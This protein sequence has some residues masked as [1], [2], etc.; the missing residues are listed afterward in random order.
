MKLIFTGD[1]NFR[2]HENLTEAGCTDILSGVL[3]YVG[4]A[5]FRIVNLE[6]PLADAHLHTPIYKSGPNLI[7]APEN[8]VFLNTFGADAVTLANNHTGDYG[9]SAVLQTMEVLRTNGIR[10]CGAGVNIADAYNACRLEKDGVT[11]SLI[12]V[13]ENE[14]G[15]ATETAAGSAGYQPRLL[16]RKIREEKQVSDAVIVVFHGGNE[17]NPLPSPDTQE[18][19]RLICDMGAD[20][21]IAGH[22]HCPQGYEMF[23]GKPIVYS[24]G[25]F[26]F[27]SSTERSSDD[28]WHYGYMTALDIGERCIDLHL[29]PYR[30]SIGADK[31][32]VFAGEDREKMLAYIDRLSGTIANPTELENYF[33][34]WSY[35][36]KWIPQAPR[37]YSDMHDYFSAGHYNLI[38]CESHY[39]QAKKVLELCFLDR[40]ED[41]AV[42]A[43]KVQEQAKM[44]V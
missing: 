10:F 31:I 5:D 44:P 13:C 39:S 16:L 32:H 11:V 15:M 29:I 3:P 24:M 12:S 37:D 36:H 6:T 8:V 40:M 17:H 25:N 20:A 9:E 23:D 14:F 28:P 33:R 30:F 27:K 43:E 41:A 18:R 21:V 42:W 26:L 19:Y 2:G 7:S 38:C 1:L 4:D 34:G 35:L 22:T